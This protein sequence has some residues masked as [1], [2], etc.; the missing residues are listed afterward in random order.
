VLGVEL[1]LCVCG[2]YGAT[3]CCGTVTV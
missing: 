1:I 3:G 2:K